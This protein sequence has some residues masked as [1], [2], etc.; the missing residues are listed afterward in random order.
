MFTP[1]NGVGREPHK[2]ITVEI[3]LNIAARRQRS[4]WL[5][6]ADAA[7]RSSRKF[8]RGAPRRA[9]LMRP[10]DEDRVR[11]VGCEQSKQIGVSQVRY[12]TKLQRPAARI[13]R[14][15]QHGHAHASE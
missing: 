6:R 14:W 5:D 12:G 13:R 11:L 4:V 7:A 15:E 3:V 2:A 10:A 1:D 8:H 9:I